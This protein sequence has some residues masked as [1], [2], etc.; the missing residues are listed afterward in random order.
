[1]RQDRRQAAGIGSVALGERPTR[2]RVHGKGRQRLKGQCV[3][4][5]KRD[6]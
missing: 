4:L 3:E 1:L 5:V 6:A 2:V